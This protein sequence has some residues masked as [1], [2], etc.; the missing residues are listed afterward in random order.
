[1]PPAGIAAAVHPS[2]AARSE[3]SLQLLPC[4]NIHLQLIHLPVILFQ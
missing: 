4:S 2:S 3:R 1:M